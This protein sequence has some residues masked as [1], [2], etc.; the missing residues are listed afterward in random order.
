MV[1]LNDLCQSQRDLCVTLR[2]FTS[3]YAVKVRGHVESVVSS[4]GPC[5][6]LSSCC[7][8]VL[9]LFLLSFCAQTRVMD[10]MLRTRTQAK[11]EQRF[12]IKFYTAQDETPVNIW[13]C[14]QRIHGP[15]TLLQTTIR[16]WY[17]KF[18]SDPNASCL[19][20]PQC[21]GLHFTCDQCTIAK[22][23]HL[24]CQDG[25]RTICQLALGAHISVGSAHKILRDDLKMK[26]WLPAWSP[27]C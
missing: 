7:Q 13:I 20:R 11:A 24:V 15:H 5:K 12:V 27:S 25:H 6:T 3:L 18:C 4:C 26:S 21:G 14:L 1:T 17:K 19:D 2:F 16:N 10:R 22:V 9:L 8:C 23:E